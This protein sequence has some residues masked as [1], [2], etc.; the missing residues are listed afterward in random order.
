MVH[1]K[2]EVELKAHL[3]EG[4]SVARFSAD[5][6]LRGANLRGADLYGAKNI[7][8]VA[9]VGSGG[10]TV[11]FVNHTDS[12]M[13]QAGCFWGTVDELL[14]RSRATGDSDHL[15]GYEAA[16]AYARVILGQHRQKYPI[17]VQEAES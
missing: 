12:I 11:Y 1:I 16:V 8:C 15:A 5:V 4:K 2:N 10:R 3:A 17:V 14:E 7:V 13:A 6:T 9:G